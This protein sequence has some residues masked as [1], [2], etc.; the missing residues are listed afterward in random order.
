MFQGR[1]N[2]TVSNCKFNDCYNCFGNSAPIYCVIST[3]N[4]ALTFKYCLFDGFPNLRH[5][6]QGCGDQ[7]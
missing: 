5:Q 6:R 2:V 4:G 1:S 7:S 3:G